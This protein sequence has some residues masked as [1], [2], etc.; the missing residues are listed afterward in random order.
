MRRPVAR[1]PPAG[2]SGVR[3][4]VLPC[5]VPRQVVEEVL[6]EVLELRPD[7]LEVEE[8]CSVEIMF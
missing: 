6:A 2:R 3:P 1:P 7:C 8:L 5:L 4:A